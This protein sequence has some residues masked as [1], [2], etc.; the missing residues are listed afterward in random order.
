MTLEH[1]VSNDIFGWFCLFCN[2]MS[3]MTFKGFGFLFFDKLGFRAFLMS[4]VSDADFCSI[5]S[6]K[7]A[8]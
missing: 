7:S 3:N 1:C 8:D 5:P 4:A 6:H 2:Y